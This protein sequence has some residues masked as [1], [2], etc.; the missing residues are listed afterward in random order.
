MTKT[1][2]LVNDDEAERQR[3][4]LAKLAPGASDPRLVRSGSSG[5]DRLSSVD[6]TPTSPLRRG[7]GCVMQRAVRAGGWFGGLSLHSGRSSTV[8]DHGILVVQAGVEGVGAA[9]AIKRAL[10]HR[11]DLG[12][13]IRFVR[14]LQPKLGIAGSQPP[15]PPLLCLQRLGQPAAFSLDAK[16]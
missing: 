3:R 5:L 2:R 14:L 1:E 15:L 16:K 9:F 13:E 12:V 8:D 4:L 10:V 11:R 7:G 6:I